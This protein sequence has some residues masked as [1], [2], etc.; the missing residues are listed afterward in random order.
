MR[1]GLIQVLSFFQVEP[2]HNKILHFFVIS[3]LSPKKHRLYTVLK[4]K[5]YKN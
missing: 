3:I 1:F 4:S 2:E 5:K